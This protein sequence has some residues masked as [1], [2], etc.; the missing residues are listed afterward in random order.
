[1]I[2]DLFSHK[3]HSSGADWPDKLVEIASIFKEFDGRIFDRAE[4]EE[5]LRSI[6]PR[7]AVFA[8]DA[9]RDPS[10]FRDEISAYPAYL[11]LYRLE[12]DGSNWILRLSE[13]AKKFLTSDEPDVATFMRLQLPLFQYPNGMGMAYSA[14][15]ARI[16]ANAR[17]RMLKLIQD[18]IHV[19]PFR[20]IC[21][22]LV[23]DSRLRGV[24]EVE[25][26]VLIS[27]LYALVNHSAINKTSSPA[28]DQIVTVLQDIRA[29]R[30]LPPDRF[31]S[32]FHI[33]DHTEMIDRQRES[34]SFRR[35][36]NEPDRVDMQKK[37][38][39]I[40]S[41]NAQFEGFDASR[42][43]DDLIDIA[44]S[45]AWG[46]YFD[47][48]RTLSADT[49]SVLAQ[50]MAMADS[51]AIVTPARVRVMPAAPLR[52]AFRRHTG[53]SV[54]HKISTRKEELADP[55]VT[56]VK[57]ER[58]SLA[59]KQMVAALD[60]LLRS[61]G[62]EPKENPHVDLYAEIPNDGAYLFEVKSGGENLLAQIRKGVS[63][64]YEYRFRY[65]GEVRADA[66]LCL[67][68]PDEPTGL[69]WLEE[70]LCVDRDISL[71]WLDQ[72]GQ[73]TSAKLCETKLN[74]FLNAPMVTTG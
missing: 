18:G 34:L 39:A 71:C 56:R 74:D 59:H 35:P 30:V 29:G 73:V 58:R 6:S 1:M 17:D 23:A 63:Q 20:L 22:A 69:S 16:Q 61:K 43:G 72:E 65:K 54:P 55:E 12:F 7:V 2:T 40:L 41:I 50:D 21:R 27:E 28:I 26:V 70:Y 53:P 67:V 10:K 57:R 14:E 48:L 52:Y 38:V 64:L 9:T 36:V 49:V 44:K 25:A 68:L 32:R 37:I 60:D 11:G 45:G 15:N 8:A 5:R 19:S 66:V 42:N 33:L 62:A 51:E 46:Q 31:E 4:I 24:D 47:G 13:S 3:I